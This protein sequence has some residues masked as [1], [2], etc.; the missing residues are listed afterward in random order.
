VGAWYEGDAGWPGPGSVYVYDANDLSAQP[1][2][3]S[4]FDGASGDKFGGSL[5]AFRN[6][7]VVGAE[8]DDDNGDRSGSV[9]V[10]DASDLSAQPTKLT[11]FDAGEYATFGESVAVG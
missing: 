7:I 4:A 8:E 9:Y 11:A 3:L 6:T 10:Y 2:K 1:T 5:D